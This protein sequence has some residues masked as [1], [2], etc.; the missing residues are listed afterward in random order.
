[1]GMPDGLQNEDRKHGAREQVKLSTPLR[2]LAKIGPKRVEL[3][4][5]L[6]LHRVVDLLFFFPRSY[7]EF[8]PIVR[9]GDFQP[10]LSCSVLGTVDSIDARTYSEGGSSF[11]AL[12]ALEGG[13]FLRLIWFNQPYLPQKI[14]R[15]MRILARG[16]TKSTGMSWQM[17]HPEFDILD[18]D[19]PIPEAKPQAV[20][21]LT[22]GLQ[23]R[24]VREA[25]AV[26]LELCNALVPESLPNDFREQHRLLDIHEALQAIHQPNDLTHAETAKY[27]FVFQELLVYQLAIAWRRFHLQTAA[28]AT[29]LPATGLIHSRILQRI[30]F[31][32]TNDQLKAVEDIG[33]DMSQ[34]VPMNRLVQGDVGSG[35]TLVAQYAM[36]LAAAHRTQSA[37]MAPTELLANQHFDRLSKSLADS[38][39]FVERLTGNL[40]GRERRELLER[41]ALG[42]VDIVV[43][44]HAL[45]NDQVEFANLGLVVIDEQH[46][47]GVAQRAALRAGQKQPHYLLL[48]ATPIPR[49]L[50]M[51]A[52]GDMDVSV[53]REKPKGRAPVHTYLGKPEQKSSWWSFVAKQ[54]RE[55]RQAYVVVPRVDSEE[56]E[57]IQGAEQVYRELID[58]PLQDFSVDLLHGRLA[59]EEKNRV[60]DAFSEGSIQVLVATTVIE[61]GIDVPNAT[62]MTIFDAD[63]LGL[64]QLHQLR[65]RVSRGS[66]PGYVC[67]FPKQGNAADENKRLAALA[68]TDD[69]FRLAELDWKIRGPGSLLGTKQSGLPPF[70]IADLVRDAEIVELTQKISRQL[71]DQD[72]QLTSPEWS[73]IRDQI[74]GKHGDMIEFGTV[75]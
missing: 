28:P 73:R 49:T 44:T 1:M 3:F 10:E 18:S 71:I 53:L 36:L 38:H 8:Q 41:I 56:S 62:V 72:P 34:T 2:Y 63:R 43:G 46:K 31:E 47:F 16:V 32:L 51:T 54:L 48:S 45:L 70:R 50:T 37:F 55:G 17:R 5:R 20:Y 13:G 21:S 23:Q 19:E 66:N 65:G 75:G 12:L 33:R 59:S 39:C 60:M 11:G 42:T 67:V 58:G 27:R 24:H 15:G 35:K 14:R 64:A 9:F 61:V 69:G 57:D 7:R 68:E 6:G 25:V 74:L 29:S 22:E 26:A 52:M 30:P 40:P 4:E